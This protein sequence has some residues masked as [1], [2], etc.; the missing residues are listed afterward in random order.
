M[1]RP[2]RPCLQC[3]ALTTRGSY[4][5]D[6]NRRRQ[7]AR[8]RARPWYTNPTYRQARARILSAARVDPDARCHLCREG[9]RA[10]DP[11]TVDHDPPVA[12]LENWWE[13][14]LLLAHRTCNSMR[15][16]R[17]AMQGGT[18]GGAATAR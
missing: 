5:P 3:K 8:N 18:G 2:P 4:C 13:A 1:R 14:R 7:R 16:K 17:I 6:C 10:G 9:Y 11:W 12:T 15:G